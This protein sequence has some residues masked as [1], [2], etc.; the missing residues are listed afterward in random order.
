MLV[1]T[2]KPRLLLAET[3]LLV[4][5]GLASVGRVCFD[6]RRAVHPPESEA[7]VLCFV[8]PHVDGHDFHDGAGFFYARCHFCSCVYGRSVVSNAR[9]GGSE[10]LIVDE[11]TAPLVTI[12]RDS[13]LSLSHRT[14]ARPPDHTRHTARH[15]MAAGK[16]ATSQLAC[17]WRKPIHSAHQEGI[18]SMRLEQEWRS[19]GCR[20]CPS[21]H[22]LPRPS[23]KSCMR[24]S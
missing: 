9:P 20:L 11:E 16:A 15:I 22:A 8:V 13:A 3:N 23:R 2:L 1:K 18:F 12:Y 21:C 17:S 10:Q 4:A 5:C 14:A 19:C 7:L 6:L 24:D